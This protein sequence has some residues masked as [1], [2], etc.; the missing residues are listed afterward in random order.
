M[1]LLSA[2]MIMNRLGVSQVP[3]V[4]EQMEDQR[5]HIVGLLDRECISLIC[6]FCTSVSHP[7]Y[8][9]IATNNALL[10]YIICIICFFLDVTVSFRGGI[11]TWLYDFFFLFFPKKKRDEFLNFISLFGL[12]IVKSTFFSFLI[13][14]CRKGDD[15]L[16]LKILNFCNQNSK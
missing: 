1:D 16:L 8:F 10:C 5:G 4:A 11:P 9:M 13:L 3:V 12:G 6:R 7:A 14:F 2:L 15:G